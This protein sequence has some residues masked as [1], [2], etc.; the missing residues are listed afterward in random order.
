MHG[1]RYGDLE[2]QGMDP[3]RLI[4]VPFALETPFFYCDRSAT[5]GQYATTSVAKENSV[6]FLAVF[7]F[8]ICICNRFGNTLISQH[9]NHL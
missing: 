4:L 9:P 8:H 2:G 5:R 6:N 7:N 3:A 1:V